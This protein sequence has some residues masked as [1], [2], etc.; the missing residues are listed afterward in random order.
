[1]GTVITIDVRDDLP[2]KDLDAA[3]DR[4]FAWLEWV[5][6]T[7]STYKPGSEISRLGRGSLALEDCTPEVREVLARC[8]ELRDFTEGYFDARA[9]PDR[10]LDPSGLVKGWAAE[11]ASDLLAATGAVNHCV[12]AA[13]DIALR[14]APEPGQRWQ[15]GIVHPLQPDALTTIVS[16]SD[17]AVATSGTYERGL[18]VFDPHTGRP[19]DELAS[20]SVIGPSLTLADAYATAALAMGTDAPVWLS[21][22]DGYESYVIDNGGFV[23]W[24]AGFPAYRI[25]PE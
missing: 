16:L 9:G 4:A 11:R 20:V 21:G 5:D 12:N 19:A 3:L 6:T 13:G 8:E 15:I 23:W 17:G 25:S 18:H 22:L 2:A 10:A 24:S 7:F 14:G 1:M